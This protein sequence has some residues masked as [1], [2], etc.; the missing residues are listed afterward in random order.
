MLFR[1][2]ESSTVL[3]PECEEAG[4]GLVDSPV[5]VSQTLRVVLEDKINLR[6]KSRAYINLMVTTRDTFPGSK[7]VS[8]WGNT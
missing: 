7:S 6:C 2:L 8:S 4:Q 3:E 1:A 5:P